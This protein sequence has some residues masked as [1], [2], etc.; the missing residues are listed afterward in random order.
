MYG[1]DIEVVGVRPKLWPEVEK[2]RFSGLDLWL[3][4]EDV[5]LSEEGRGPVHGG[6]R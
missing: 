4:A 6:Q 3:G 2:S 5:P 1:L